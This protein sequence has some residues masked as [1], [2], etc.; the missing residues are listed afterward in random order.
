MRW[1]QGHG[2]RRPSA[3]LMAGKIRE[4]LVYTLILQAFS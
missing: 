3:G 4:K 2:T 1:R